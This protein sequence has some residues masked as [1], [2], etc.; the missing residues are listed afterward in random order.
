MHGLCLCKCCV[1]EEM[2]GALSAAGR[3]LWWLFISLAAAL[4][5]WAG[6]MDRADDFFPLLHE[7]TT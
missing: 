4:Q 7:T 3:R 5:L 6:G 2:S 1:A